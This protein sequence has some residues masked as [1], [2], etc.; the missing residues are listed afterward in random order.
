MRESGATTSQYFIGEHLFACEELRLCENQARVERGNSIE[1]SE[2]ERQFFVDG[3]AAIEK[4]TRPV[5]VA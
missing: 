3:C 2:V 1:F 5:R 4:I